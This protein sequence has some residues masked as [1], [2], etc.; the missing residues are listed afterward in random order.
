M[1]FAAPALCSDAGVAPAPPLRSDVAA[2]VWPAGPLHGRTIGTAVPGSRTVLL[3]GDSRMANWGLPQIEG[4]RM[5]NAGCG[6]HHRPTGVAF[7][8][9]PGSS[10]TAGR[11]RSSRDQR[12]QALASART[13]LIGHRQLRQQYSGHGGECR[14]AGARVFVTPV[15]PAGEVTP[16]RRL[17]WSG[18][19]WTR[20]WRKPTPVSAPLADKDGVYVAEFFRNSPRTFKAIANDCMSTPCISSRKPMSAC[21]CCWRKQSRAGADDSKGTGRPERCEFAR[22]SLKR[23]GKTSLPRPRQ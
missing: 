16:G 15:W 18:P 23:R 11:G 3:M 22:S 10:A 20:R 19:H 21:R 9:N 1:L 17:V 14:R 5:L 13:S 7:P 12:P 4:W 6:S 8:G 2:K